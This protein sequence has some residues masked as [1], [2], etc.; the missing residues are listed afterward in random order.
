[1]NLFIL[2]IKF[3]KELDKNIY[4]KITRLHTINNLNIRGYL[5]KTNGIGKSFVDHFCNIIYI[6]EVNI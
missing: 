2:K 6:K 3:T 5:L 4:F 1:M